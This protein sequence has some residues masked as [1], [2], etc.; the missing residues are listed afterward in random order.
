MGTYEV[1]DETMPKITNY[2]QF[3][4]RMLG[5]MVD[6]TSRPRS[7]TKYVIV[8]AI[9][10]IALV[11]IL[12]ALSLSSQPPQSGNGSPTANITNDNANTAIPQDATAG[13]GEDNPGP[14]D[15]GGVPD[16]DPE[17]IPDVTPSA[18]IS[19]SPNPATPGSEIDIEGSGFDGNQKITLAV[20]NNSI[21]TEPEEIMTDEAGNF[22]T[23]FTLSEG[24]EGE[25]E[26][27][28][29][30]ASGHVASRNLSVE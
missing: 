4:L 7:V 10:V 2:Y 5:I 19:A 30:D 28:A 24:Q 23:K 6:Q 9:G 27:I 26:I 22:S 15:G 3:F 12:I 1:Y 13:A 25:L 29:T 14:I 16:T 17:P 20:D 21:Q 8:G 18:A 11:G